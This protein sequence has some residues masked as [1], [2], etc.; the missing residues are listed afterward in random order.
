MYYQMKNET[1]ILY[2]YIMLR[3]RAYIFKVSCHLYE[4]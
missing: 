3:A 4:L 1:Q 2:S